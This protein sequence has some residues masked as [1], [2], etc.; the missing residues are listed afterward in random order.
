MPLPGRDE[1]IE[2]PVISQN[3]AV[4]NYIHALHRFM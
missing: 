3:K 2:I 1:D 4:K